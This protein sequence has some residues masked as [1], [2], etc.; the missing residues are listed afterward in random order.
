M[1]IRPDGVVEMDPDEPYPVACKLCGR[2]YQPTLGSFA[3]R[4]RACGA[5]NIHAEQVW[6]EAPKTPKRVDD[7]G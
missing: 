2:I 3:S 6:Y 4:C 5:G 1:R 7:G